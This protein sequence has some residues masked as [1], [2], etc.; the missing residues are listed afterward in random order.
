[1]AEVTNANGKKIDFG[2]AVNL[3]DDVIREALAGIESEQDFFDAYSEEHLRVFG[4][5][6]E[7]SKANPVW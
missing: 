3:M 2:A 7:L 4:V 6:W 5:E 1:M